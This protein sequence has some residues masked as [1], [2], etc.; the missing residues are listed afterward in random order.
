M[1]LSNPDI[2]SAS[3]PEAKSVCPCFAPVTVQE[4]HGS[5]KPGKVESIKI[6]LVW[7]KGKLTRIGV[8]RLIDTTEPDVDRCQCNTTNRMT[9]LIW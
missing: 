6:M 2:L 7:N 9:L 1:A 3:G 8:N 4:M 5:F